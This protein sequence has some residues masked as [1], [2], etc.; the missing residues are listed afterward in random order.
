[1]EGFLKL[2]IKKYWILFTVAA[3]LIILDQWTKHWVRTT[4]P[5]GGSWMPIEWLAPYFRLVHWTN[6]GVAFGMFQGK[7]FIFAI[8]AFI[9]AG[10][11]IYYYPQIPE[12]DWIM[13]VALGF[14]LGGAL[15]NLIDRI[16]FNFE[17]TDFIS[18]GNFAVYNIAD[19]SITV[20]VAILLLAVWIKDSQ[21]K[22]E[23]ILTS[24][25][26]DVEILQDESQN[27][28]N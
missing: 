25:P 8:L 26:D 16:L 23:S 5:Y 10:A 19:A 1:M 28:D 11:I 21:D 20:G 17:V 9:V 15:G 14:Q 2:F 12:K 13:R 3:V 4:I 6:T 22:E 27:C 7:G 18:M 24:L